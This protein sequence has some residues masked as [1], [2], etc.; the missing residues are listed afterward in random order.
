[1]TI[2]SFIS[3]LLR[4]RNAMQA[5]EFQPSM[6]RLGRDNPKL[7]QMLQKWATS[8]AIIKSTPGQESE[9]SDKFRKIILSPAFFALC[10]RQNDTATAH[11]AMVKAADLIDTDAS[12]AVAI[13]MGGAFDLIKL[14]SEHAGR[15][16]PPLGEIEQVRF[17]C[18]QLREMD[19]SALSS[20]L[21]LNRRP[22]HSEA[23][24]CDLIC[25]EDECDSIETGVLTEETVDGLDRHQLSWR[26]AGHLAKSQASPA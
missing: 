26:C 1:M 16:L 24:E 18:D 19:R 8:Q 23:I 22:S 15:Q 10:S 11:F 9:A 21:I 6:E 5:G 3:K 13:L 20:Y 4:R 2:K 14:L 17:L 25:S 7:A 12:E